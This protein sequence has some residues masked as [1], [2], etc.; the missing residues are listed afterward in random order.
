MGYFDFIINI[1][2]IVALAFLAIMEIRIF[3]ELF[4]DIEFIILIYSKIY[5]YASKESQTKFYLI[6]GKKYNGE[7]LRVWTSFIVN[8]FLFIVI[9]IP[10]Y[11]LFNYLFY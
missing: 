1:F 2:S 11:F 4:K 8:I 9:S 10:I 6:F 5:R 3:I 7:M